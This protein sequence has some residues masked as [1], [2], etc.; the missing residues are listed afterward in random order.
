MAVARLDYSVY[1]VLDTALSLEQIADLFGSLG[2]WIRKWSWTGHEMRCPW[3]ELYLDGEGEILMHGP[4]ADPLIHAEE[5][6][7]PL[8]SAGVR[9]WGEFYGPKSELLQEFSG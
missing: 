9:F 3:A 4:I 8:R 1:S 5:L 6:F 2:W 7:T